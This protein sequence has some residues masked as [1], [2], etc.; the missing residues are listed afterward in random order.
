MAA[1]NFT[2]G[3][4]VRVISPTRSVLKLLRQSS[5]VCR[6]GAYT[7][8][9]AVTDFVRFTSVPWF[10]PCLY[11]VYSDSWF[12]DKSWFWRT[13]PEI[14]V[15]IIIL[16]CFCI[17]KATTTVQS[18]VVCENSAYGKKKRRKTVTFFSFLCHDPGKRKIPNGK[19]SEEKTRKI[20][21]VFMGLSTC[22]TWRSKQRCFSWRHVFF[23][24][25]PRFFFHSSFLF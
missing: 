12:T 5:R 19:Q 21:N 16:N 17:K 13:L 20:R 6:T 9:T 15:I 22:I 10:C 2:W 11:T 23:S 24:P 4:H 25:I 1:I 7:W 8:R 18:F 3:L 14:Y